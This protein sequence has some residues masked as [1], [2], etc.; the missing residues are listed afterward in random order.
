M[1]RYA[2]LDLI[3]SSA[4]E[5]HAAIGPES[6]CASRGQGTSPRENVTPDSPLRCVDWFAQFSTKTVE[7]TTLSK[8]RVMKKE[9]LKSRLKKY[10]R[11]SASSNLA[12]LLMEMEYELKTSKIATKRREK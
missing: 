3:P 7:K 1:P 11:Q 5:T 6:S 9:Y 2:K 8:K 10:K 4:M 12:N